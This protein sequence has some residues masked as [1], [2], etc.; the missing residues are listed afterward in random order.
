MP[1]LFLEESKDRV[2]CVRVTH[3][4][5]RIDAISCNFW[6][7]MIDQYSGFQTSF[8]FWFDRAAL[9][10]GRPDMLLTEQ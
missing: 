1:P 7:N 9:S 3:P 4:C 5:R 8:S 2:Q 6:I 10:S